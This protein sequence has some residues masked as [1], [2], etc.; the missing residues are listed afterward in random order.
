MK[1]GT[2]DGDLSLDPK[3]MK[4]AR[5]EPFSPGEITEAEH[6]RGRPTGSD[7]WTRQAS[8]SRQLAR[9]NRKDEGFLLRGQEAVMTFN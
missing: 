2:L 5:E 7:S 9:N 4:K 3:S 6:R 8:A 1:T